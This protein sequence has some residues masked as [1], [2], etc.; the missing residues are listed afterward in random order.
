M[1]ILHTKLQDIL[2]NVA[3]DGF[4]QAM[5]V[6]DFDTVCL[7][8]D[9]ANSANMKIEVFGT[10]TDKEP[11]WSSAQSLTNRYYE[12]ETINYDDG[13]SV[14][15]S[16]GITLAGTDTHRYLE[17]NTNLLSFINIKISSYVAG[18]ITVSTRG[19]NRG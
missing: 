1:S 5:G 3:A 4:G 11:T 13:T 12:L 14:D 10:P 9:T 7:T 15:G 17:I 6:I 19:C 16:T 8:I 2:S 18:N